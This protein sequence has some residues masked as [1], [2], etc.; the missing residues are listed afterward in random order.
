[1]LQWIFSRCGWPQDLILQPPT[2]A[3]ADTPT[4]PSALFEMTFLV[5]VAIPSSSSR[6]R[7]RSTISFSKRCE[8]AFVFALSNG[9]RFGVVPK[10]F[11]Q[12][13]VLFAG[14][15]AAVSSQCENRS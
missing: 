12:K 6:T 10:S 4:D 5:S 14:L 13:E 8:S 15:T 11:C 3:F 1:P 2:A 7:L 9:G